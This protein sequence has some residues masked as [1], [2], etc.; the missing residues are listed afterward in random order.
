MSE[1]PSSPQS[2]RSL[3]LLSLPVGMGYVPMGA[4][5][6]FLLMQAG[7]QWWMGLLSSVL[8]YAG[9][10][11]FMVIPMLVA[12]ESFV[13]VLLATFVINLRH[14]FY[15]L[16]ILRRMPRNPW[17]RWYLVGALTDETYALL[18]TLPP[19]AGTRE[20]VRLAALNQLWWVSG[21]LLGVV[22]GAQARLPFAGLD[23][24]VAALFAVLVVEVWF[25]SRQTRAVVVALLAYMLATWFWPQQ[26]LVLAIAVCAIAAL[27]P[28]TQSPGALKATTSA[29][30]KPLS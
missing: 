20:W 22:L 5:Y 26:A 8:V 19:S 6:G 24:S 4:I 25:A 3:L 30:E 23:F 18:T 12:G 9:A 11:Q 29:A 1:A 27:L 13:A 17:A 15:G 21:T 14:V 7:G 16:S 2:W 28:W 10:A